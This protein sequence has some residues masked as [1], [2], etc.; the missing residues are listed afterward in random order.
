M[1]KTFSDNWYRVADLRIGLRPTVD[2]RVQYYGEEPWY[3]LHERA[4]NSFHRVSPD[5]WNFLTRLSVESTVDEVWRASIEA[6][7]EETPGQEDVF[8]LL[9]SLYR[10][11]LIHIEGGADERRLVER[12]ADKKRKPVLARL[13][14]LMFIRIPL[15]DPEPYL[16]RAEPAIRRV[17]SPMGVLAA[18]L[19]VGW[20]LVELALSGRSAW[21]QADRLLQ[22]NN[23]VLLYLAVFLAKAL[24]ELG[25]AAMCKRFGGEVHT[26][27]LMLLMFTP[28]P[29]VDVT[30]SWALR[31]RWQRALIGAAGMLA[32]IV[33]AA[34]ATIVWAH[35]PPGMVNELAYNLMFSTAVYTL[36]FNL[37]PLMRFDGY[38]ILADLAG[39]PNLHEQ[40]RNQFR[41]WFR[42]RALQLD[43]GIIEPD[44]RVRS[45]LL[46]TFFVAS[47][48]YRLMVMLGIVLLIADAYL[49]LG[50]VVAV[51]LGL[52]SFVLPLQQGWKTLRSPLFQYQRKLLIRRVAIGLGVL[53]LFFLVIP[54][55]DN[56][57]LPG[58]VEARPHTRIYSEAGGIVA[59]VLTVSGV[60]VNGATVLVQL[61]NPELDSEIVG[62]DA[63]IAQAETLEARSL[64]EGG[65]DLAPV[66]ERLKT[67]TEL[68]GT[69]LRQKA[70]LTVRAPHGGYWVA[71]EVGYR[72]GEWVARGA[73][74]G[75]VVD[76]R[77]HRFVGVISQEAGAV[78]TGARQDGIQVRLEG[79]LGEVFR[80]TALTLVPYSQDM[81]PSAALSPLAGGEVPI[82]AADPSGKRSAEP[83]FILHANIEA[84]A[85]GSDYEPV[86]A[87]RSGWIRVHLPAR[88]LAAQLWTSL[89]QFLERRYHL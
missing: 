40:A 77:Q 60:R 78:L 65:V 5:T 67:L 24:H 48:V 43:D 84:P 88:P 4:H 22:L 30:S 19:I 15:L 80:A 47:N 69:L 51:A 71:P 61:E 74:L 58:V 54:M 29:Y 37:N 3:V 41:R 49:G 50:L 66:E 52:T 21:N 26:I 2:V 68:K 56:R 36:V 45:V 31:N 8:Q 10:S 46:A 32:D 44:E 85:P 64:T 35:S 11:N 81:L 89:R 39:V 34:I 42:S 75:E 33:V 59:R 70:A 13:S 12:G 72:L 27:G 7:P 23:V 73:E 83:F 14:E 57:V 9:A 87:G 76:D 25:H 55:P 28:L 38:Y 53:L 86:R 79:A 17:F 20:G 6:A 82:A 62:V 63:Q 16:R 18:S 1:G